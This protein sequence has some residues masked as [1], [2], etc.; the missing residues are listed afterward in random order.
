MATKYNRN[1]EIML[2]WCEECDAKNRMLDSCSTGAARRE[3]VLFYQTGVEFERYEKG[4]FFCRNGEK[5]LTR[6][7]LFL[8]GT[9]VLR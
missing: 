2:E 1:P 4:V 8:A 7:I 9:G 6:K 3:I 5:I